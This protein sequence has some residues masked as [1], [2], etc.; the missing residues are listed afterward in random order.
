[1]RMKTSPVVGLTRRQWLKAAGLA[2]GSLV[3]SCEWLLRA[4]QFVTM[5]IHSSQAALPPAAKK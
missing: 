3:V 2:A 4:G 5:T 1:M